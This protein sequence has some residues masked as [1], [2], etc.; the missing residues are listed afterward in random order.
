MEVWCWPKHASK[1]GRARW[2]RE[3]FSTA[4]VGDERRVR[5]LVRIAEA[6]VARPAGTI[7]EVFQSSAEREAA[8]RL[9]SNEQVKSEAL[10]EAVFA[11]TAR[12]CK[13]EDVIY[14][15]VDGSSLSVVDRRQARDVG[16]VGAWSQ[17]GRGMH[18]VSALALDQHGVAI[19]LCA[20]SWWARTTPAKEPH[21]NFRPLDE[22][23]SRFLTQTVRAA[24]A[25]LRAGSKTVIQLLDRGFDIAS[26]LM[27][28]CDDE[29]PCRFILRA[30]QNR[31]IASSKGE[32]PRYLR[33]VLQAAPIIGRYDVSVT[34]RWDRPARIARVQVQ[35]AAV[36]VEVPLT[37]T[38][39][40]VVQLNAVL[41]RELSGAKDALSWMLLTTEGID[42]FDDVRQIVRAYSYRWRIE[43]MHRA[44]KRGG[45]NVE[46]TQLRSRD[47]FLK[48]A[49]IHAAVAARAVRLSHRARSEPKV[50]ATEE[51]SQAEINAVIALRGKHTKLRTGAVP[52]LQTMVRLV[53]DAG[54]Y[55]GKSSGGPPGPTVI[56]RGLQR[57][58]IVVEAFANV[59]NASERSDE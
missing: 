40:Q 9:L 57:I 43:E 49:T 10:A 12:H 23:E 45:C 22:K 16:F 13:D 42:T 47:G 32:S 38:R 56:S 39:W 26:V 34:E 51:F 2:A 14:V 36:T 25:R 3:T 59:A 52:D 17:G 29:T 1:S 53:A 48:W 5:R 8:Y 18:V 41:V 27:L 6:V 21:D 35:A 33:N 37:K 4:A 44:W 54:G 30:S 46:D 15:A 7:T 20:Q 55:T 11:T 58:A 28:A 24:D 31:R 50:P 19:G